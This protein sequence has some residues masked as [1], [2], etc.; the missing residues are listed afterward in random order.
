[1]HVKC[2]SFGGWL[3]SKN[4]NVSLCIVYR[5][6]IHF[7]IHTFKPFPLGWV[8]CYHPKLSCI[9][10]S[11]VSPSSAHL[12]FSSLPWSSQ[13]IKTWKKNLYTF[14]APDSVYI[15]YKVYATF[16]Q[17]F[18]HFIKPFLK[19]LPLYSSLIPLSLLL[20]AKI[21]TTLSTINF[22]ISALFWSQKLFS[23]C[24]LLRLVAL[25]SVHLSY[26]LI[27][28]PHCPCDFYIFCYV[29]FPSLSLSLI[30]AYCSWPQSRL[31][32]PI[33]IPHWYVY[34]QIFTNRMM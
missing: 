33:N 5:N 6:C 7:I 14:R 11:L 13:A 27:Q 25:K 30:S 2:V 1:M 34:F 20:Q 24:W 18:F 12:S 15:K 17:T 21:V 29:F 19:L 3:F 28:N 10:L 16:L 8:Y 23:S 26:L 31:L 22:K 32:S 4:V 9:N